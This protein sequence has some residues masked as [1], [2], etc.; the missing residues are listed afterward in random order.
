MLTRFFDVL[1]QY[2]R[3]K[4]SLTLTTPIQFV[5]RL[6][7]MDHR[8]QLK[9]SDVVY[10]FLFLCRRIL[11]CRLIFS[12]TKQQ[13]QQM[14]T[15]FGNMIF[16]RLSTHTDR[17][18]FRSCWPVLLQLVKCKYIRNERP[19]RGYLAQVSISFSTNKYIRFFTKSTQFFNDTSFENPTFKF[20]RLF[21]L[22]QSGAERVHFHLFCFGQHSCVK[23]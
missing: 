5:R 10:I 4:S 19:T 17:L 13:Q 12:L 11:T 9:R 15:A 22:P 20:S 3:N 8:L 18:L 1:L 7:A 21:R 2:D 6:A 23:Y 16:S 14:I